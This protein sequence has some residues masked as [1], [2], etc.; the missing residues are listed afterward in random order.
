MYAGFVSGVVPF[1]LSVVL[2]DVF[3]AQPEAPVRPLPAE[4][5]F[6]LCCP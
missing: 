3:V 6:A 1:D 4:H 2:E 5:V